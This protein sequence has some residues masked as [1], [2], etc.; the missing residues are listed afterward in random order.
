MVAWLEKV[1]SD[2]ILNVYT[3]AVLNCSVMSDSLQPHR[4]YPA[5][6]PGS[7]VHGIFQARI[8]KWL[9]KVFADEMDMEE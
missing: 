8:L 7:S 4:L 5:R 9:A 2:Q 6:L 3:G 1:R